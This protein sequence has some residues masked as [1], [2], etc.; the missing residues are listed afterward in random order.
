MSRCG[1]V[2]RGPHRTAPRGR[3]RTGIRVAVTASDRTT[4]LLGPHDYTTRSVRPQRA[5]RMIMKGLEP[6]THFHYLTQKYNTYLS[7]TS[8]LEIHAFVD[9]S[10]NTDLF[11]GTRLKFLGNVG[12]VLT[13]CL[14]LFFEF[15]CIAD[16]RFGFSILK[17]GRSN[18]R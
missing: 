2:P 17:K 18:I 13:N 4:R 10:C 14:D 5:I 7:M 11:L 16:V 8:E 6:K 12:S 15:F 1:I 9:P 3:V